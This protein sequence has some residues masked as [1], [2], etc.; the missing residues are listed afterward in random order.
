MKLPPIPP[1]KKNI[2]L[3][4]GSA[5]LVSVVLY[6]S[7]LALNEMGLREQAA[8]G[9]ILEKAYRPAYH[10]TRM[11]KSGN[12]YHS[13]PSYTP[14]AWLVT[15]RVDGSVGTGDVPRADYDKFQIGET[16]LV[17]YSRRRIT[18]SMRVR[19]MIKQEAD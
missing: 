7:F 16:V 3:Y 17:D 19:G 1:F 8:E 6:L 11:V 15:V 9:Q 10:G 13:V 12:S 2:L 14:E 18:R 4:F 5:V